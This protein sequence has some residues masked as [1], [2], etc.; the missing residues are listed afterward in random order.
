VTKKRISCREWLER[1]GF[2][3]GNTPDSTIAEAEIPPESPA[4]RRMPLPSAIVIHHSATVSGSTRLFRCFHRVVNGWDDIGYHYVI[5]NGTDSGDGEVEEGR[6][7]TVRGA[8]AKG[9]NY[10]SVG[11]CLVGN[12]EEHDPSTEQLWSLGRLLKGL[13]E[14]F[15]IKREHI[16]LHRDV[17]GCDTVCPGE[18]LSLDTVIAQIVAAS[19]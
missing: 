4:Y 14:R 8:H 9:F 15:H 13:M 12:F 19:L 6:P 2:S 17:E 3:A 1:Q 16:I 7:A 5:G 18:H 10:C 11:V